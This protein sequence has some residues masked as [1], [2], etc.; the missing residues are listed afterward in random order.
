MEIDGDVE[1][2]IGL[3]DRNGDEAM[4][5]NRSTIKLHYHDAKKR[6][7]LIEISIKSPNTIV[8]RSQ[9]Q[10]YL[11]NG[12]W[13]PHYGSVE[14]R[15]ETDLQASPLRAMRVSGALTIHSVGIERVTE[16]KAWP[17]MDVS[18]VFNCDLFDQPELKTRDLLSNEPIR[19][20]NRTLDW[21][22]MS[23]ADYSNHT[24][25]GSTNWMRGE[26]LWLTANMQNDMPSQ[27]DTNVE[28]GLALS[29]ITRD[30]AMR[31]KSGYLSARKG[32][33]IGEEDVQNVLTFLINGLKV[34]LLG[35]LY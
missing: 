24:Y 21:E 15:T 33:A 1:W 13:R 5:F 9:T 30:E 34:G 20:W 10:E 11:E 19:F 16:K 17:T 29:N 12:G 7:V 18:K 26:S 23:P 35:S 31:G 32:V 8:F 28:I 14:V 25:P 27:Q 4:N 6:G 2:A 22:P 3:W